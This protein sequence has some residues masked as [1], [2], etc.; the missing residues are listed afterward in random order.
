[1]PRRDVRRAAS[2]LD[3]VLAGEVLRQDME[4]GL[5]HP[6]DAPGRFLARP[7]AFPRPDILRRA[8]VPVDAVA[9]Y[10][11]GQLGLIVHR[12]PPLTILGPGDS[13]GPCVTAG[14]CAYRVIPPTLLATSWPPGGRRCRTPQ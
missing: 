10:V 3:H 11:L 12:A 8:R 4:L 5:W 6:P 13:Y 2:E 1:Q 14:C 9:P 7:G